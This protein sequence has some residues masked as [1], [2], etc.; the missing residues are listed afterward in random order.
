[1]EK[2]AMKE[3]VG[4]YGKTWHFWQVDAGH[5][6]PLGQPRLMGSATSSEQID[7]DQ[8]LKR[9]NDLFGVHHRDKAEQRKDIEPPEIHPRKFSFTGGLCKT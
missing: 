7:L 9:R 8:A 4:L 2:E 3:I 5:E 6:Y 1:M